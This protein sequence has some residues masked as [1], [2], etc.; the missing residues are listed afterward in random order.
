MAQRASKAQQGSIESLSLKFDGGLNLSEAPSNIADNELTRAYNYIY[1]AATGTPIVRPG[2]TCQTA[3]TCD[4]T[5][6]ILKICNY[7]KSS[8]ESWL[9]A[10]CNGNLYYLSGAGLDGWTKIGALNDVTTIPC[11]LTFHAKLLI[12]DGGTNIKT[13]DGTTYSALADGLAATAITAIKG[14]V[15]VNS[16]TAGSNDLVTFSGPED[17]TK[18]NT[19]TEGA[20][21]L[22][23]G[24][25]DNMRV[26]G[27]AVFGDDIIVSKKGDSEK[28]LYRINISDA[29]TTNW[30]V[31]S[32]NEN[33][34]SVSP[35][36]IVS[37]FNNVF[38]ADTNGFKSLKGVTEYGDLQVDFSNAK[39]NPYFTS[40]TN[41]HEMVYIPYFSA[42]WF[43]ISEHVYAFHNLIDPQGNTITAFTEMAFA[44]GLI[45]S[46][47]QVDEN[48][49]YM[50]GNNGYL[51][52]VDLTD[53]IGTDETAP[54]VTATF[55]ATLQ[56]KEFPF[57]GGGI[58]RRCEIYL[59][60]LLSGNAYLYAGTTRSEGVL[61]KAITLRNKADFLYDATGYLY[62]ATEFLHDMGKT[63]WYELSRNRTRGGSI[64]FKLT[65]TSGRVGVEGM[66]AEVA[67]VEG[68]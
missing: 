40:G 11:F 25:G 18:W 45:K 56:T 68:D 3:A 13:W 28:R 46:I 62:D 10:V 5:W 37:A 60:P 39:M 22:R 59:K 6:P 67:L 38:F 17:E 21:A 51:Y 50:A 42:I 64:Q 43:S 31:S 44:Q 57:F 47:C 20:V 53:A 1:D 36:T 35:H 4:S 48:T 12:A 14:R 63:P 2:T 66:K 55:T 29:T 30:T 9:V 8:A 49:V 26:N 15:V 54:G 41:C 24:F 34:C 16:T 32:L 61:I 52:K 7:E 23:A 19:A 58:L 27:F 65:S 33:N